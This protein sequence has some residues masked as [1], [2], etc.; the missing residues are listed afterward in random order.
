MSIEIW[1]IIILA[2]ILIAVTFWQGAL[3]PLE[4]GPKYGLGPRDEPVHKSV[5]QNR[6]TR[7]VQNHM[8]AMLMYIPLAAL[9]VALD[10]TGS[11][12]ALAAWLVIGSRTLSCSCISSASSR[13]ALSPISSAWSASSSWP[14]R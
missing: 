1:S 9:A 11:G 3:V 10:K 8:E 12:S 6:F 7:L 4:Q 2:I 5:L 13:C 14:G